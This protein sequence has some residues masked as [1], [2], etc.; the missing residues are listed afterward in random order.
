MPT[1]KNILGFANRWYPL[2]IAHANDFALKHLI[3]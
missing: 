3:I 2:A 1:D